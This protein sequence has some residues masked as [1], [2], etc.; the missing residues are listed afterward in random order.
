MWY[1]FLFLF[2]YLV[3]KYV[4]RKGVFPDVKIIYKLVHSVAIFYLALR[5]WGW[6]FTMFRIVLH[7]HEWLDS[8]KQE[9]R[10]YSVNVD[11]AFQS[12]GAIVGLV[13]TLW[14]YFML[15]GQERARQFLP[16]LLPSICIIDC[17]QAIA[18][19]IR[20]HHMQP[21]LALTFGCLIGIIPYLFIF[22]FY[23]H[24]RV[25]ESLFTGGRR[26]VEASEQSP[27]HRSR[28]K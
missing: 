23:R 24:P 3:W 15:R 19:V 13:G 20:V 8:L 5:C 28:R 17:Y 26:E 2:I 18:D 14:C 25:I 11:I 6:I 27:A 9:T 4:F 16:L 10:F 22:V 1:L 12:L 7:P 21:L